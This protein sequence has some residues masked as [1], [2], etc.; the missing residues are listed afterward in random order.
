MGEGG[1][2]KRGGQRRLSTWPVARRASCSV[3]RGSQLCKNLA[4]ASRNSQKGPGVDVCKRLKEDVAVQGMNGEE[5][6]DSVGVA[7]EALGKKM[8]PI[9]RHYP[10]EWGVFT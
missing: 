4:R 7:R 6:P 1:E 2:I 5:E 3:V 8:K 9:R 10:Q